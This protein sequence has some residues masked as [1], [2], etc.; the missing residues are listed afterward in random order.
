MPDFYRF[1]V[2]RFSLV[3]LA[4]KW[5]SGSGRQEFTTK[6]GFKDF[7]ENPVI[8]PVSN[9][10]LPPVCAPLKRR[11][12]RKMQKRVFFFRSAYVA[13]RISVNFGVRKMHIFNDFTN[14]ATRQNDAM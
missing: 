7:Y 3:S 5:K 1:F 10:I 14:R 11:A 8:N 13:T 2:G 4:K 6:R 9:F 12:P